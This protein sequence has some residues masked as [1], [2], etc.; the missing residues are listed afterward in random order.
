MNSELRR[1]CIPNS[2]RRNAIEESDIKI[3]YLKTYIAGAPEPWPKSDDSTSLSAVAYYAAVNRL[4]GGEDASGPEGDI[5]F[6]LM[7]RSIMASNRPVTDRSSDK[8][9]M[10]YVF[11]HLN[12]L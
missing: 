1:F 4:R 9:S 6:R 2:F 11:S 7:H 10:V 3:D 8:R 5:D 12:Q